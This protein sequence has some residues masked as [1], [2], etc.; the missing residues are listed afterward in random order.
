MDQK[1]RLSGAS[2]VQIDLSDGSWV[3]VKG[4]MDFQSFQVFAGVLNDEVKPAEQIGITLEFLAKVIIDWNFI[5]GD[6]KIVEYSEEKVKE[7]D[8]ETINEIIEKVIEI[9]KPEKKSSKS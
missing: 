7:M 4:K 6:G 8:V 3:K 9:Y 2:P 5:D 1:V